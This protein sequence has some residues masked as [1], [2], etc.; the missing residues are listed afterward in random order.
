MFDMGFWEIA[1]IFILLLLVV[2]PDK[3]PGLARTIGLW[4]GKARS[5]VSSVK[6]EVEQEMRLQDIQRSL[7]ENSATSEIK[8]L[9]DQVR[10]INSEVHSVGS[11][12]KTRLEKAAT[13]TPSAKPLA[14]TSAKESASGSSSPP[15]AVSPDNP[16]QD[17]ADK[18]P[19]TSNNATTP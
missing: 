18:S 12:V 8:R 16:P 17:H 6:R 15:Q 19:S 4:V 3:L 2:G 1:L 5:M 7:S 11:D 14:E 9:A 10:S 13:S